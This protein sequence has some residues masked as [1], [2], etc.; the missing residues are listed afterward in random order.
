MVAYAYFCEVFVEDVGS[1][2]IAVHPAVHN[3]LRSFL[4]PGNVLAGTS[5][6]DALLC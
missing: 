4:S 5:V 1:V 6:G 3:L 2:A